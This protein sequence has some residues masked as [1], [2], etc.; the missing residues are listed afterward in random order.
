[1]DELLDVHLG[2]YPP[3]EWDAIEQ[4]QRH[5]SRDSPGRRRRPAIASEEIAWS[6]LGLRPRWVGDDTSTAVAAINASSFAGQG[7]DELDRFRRGVRQRHELGLFV[8]TMGSLDEDE[9][10]PVSSIF[11]R[12]AQVWIPGFDSFSIGGE[13]IRL[14]KSPTVADGLS[15]ADHD[16]ALRIIN[17]RPAE[18]PWWWLRVVVAE[19]VPRGRPVGFFGT[20]APLMVSPAGET[21]AAVWTD[22]E[23]GDPD[24]AVERHYVL[25]A[26]PSHRQV[27]DWLAQQA[28]PELVPAAAS[29]VHRYVADQPDLQTLEE[30]QLRARIEELTR[31]FDEQHRELQELLA[32]E[33][34]RAHEVREPLL[35]GAG[36]ALQ[37]AVA[38]VLADAGMTVSAL[39]PLV[40]TRS[41]DL[42]VGHGGRNKLVEVKS[43]SG[44]ASESLVD[45]PRRHLRTWPQ[46]QPEVVVDGAVLVVNHQHRLPPAERSRAVYGRLEFVGSLEIPVVSAVQLFDWWR[47]AD[48]AAIRLAFGFAASAGDAEPE[49]AAP[50][51]PRVAAS[52]R[53]RWLRRGA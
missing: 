28:I 38:R 51:E 46:L 45:A 44:N 1:M 23:D 36:D 29:R 3:G 33:R 39:D 7:A 5:F 11:G 21:V 2:T 20:W 43:S 34:A 40:G 17:S 9:P 22:H 49:K 8:W 35:F 13:L 41:A 26:L 12:D 48:F 19:Q 37:D 10:E 30:Q 24:G 15:R 16:L 14:A 4:R 6:D 32:A 31:A 47:R 25:P 50:A 18:L 42:V 53:S 52:V 27:L